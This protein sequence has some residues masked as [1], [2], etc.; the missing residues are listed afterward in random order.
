M[1]D[2]TVTHRSHRASTPNLITRGFSKLPKLALLAFLY[3]LN[4][5]MS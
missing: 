2:E 5:G 3:C 4:M 1:I